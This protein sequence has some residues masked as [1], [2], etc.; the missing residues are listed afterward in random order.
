M[1]ILNSS[2]TNDARRTWRA[3]MKLPESGPLPKSYTRSQLPAAAV[4]EKAAMNVAPVV[5]ER[6]SVGEESAVGG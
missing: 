4:K 2:F 1:L 5:P 3:R 6:V